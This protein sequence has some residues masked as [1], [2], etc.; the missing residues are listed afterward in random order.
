VPIDPSQLL[1][2]YF[3]KSRKAPGNLFVIPL[4]FC[5][6]S[7]GSLYVR[8][9]YTENSIPDGGAVDQ[10]INPIGSGSEVLGSGAA[11]D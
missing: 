7:F 2:P 9:L 1:S 4:A 8:P 6:V 3:G 11:T 10:D 5:L